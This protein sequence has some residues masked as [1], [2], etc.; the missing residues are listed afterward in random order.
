MNHIPVHSENMAKPSPYSLFHLIYDIVLRCIKRCLYLLLAAPIVF[1][2]FFLPSKL[3]SR[4]SIFLFVLHVSAT[5]NSTERTLDL[6]ISSFVLVCR[7]VGF[8]MSVSLLKYY[9]AMLILVEIYFSMLLSAD[10]K[11]PR[12]CSPSLELFLSQW[13]FLCCVSAVS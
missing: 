13:S 6:C 5:D 1:S 9:A 3:M 11:L 12:S 4:F 2:G 8:Q 10:M 7:V